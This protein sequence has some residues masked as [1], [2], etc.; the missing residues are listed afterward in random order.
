MKLENAQNNMFHSSFL[1]HDSN[2]LFYFDL[3]E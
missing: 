1:V 2:V 3:I